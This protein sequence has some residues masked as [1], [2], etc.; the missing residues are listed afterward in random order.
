MTGLT[1]MCCMAA[2]FFVAS[3]VINGTI[4]SSK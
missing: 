1:F 3:A 2:L 4:E